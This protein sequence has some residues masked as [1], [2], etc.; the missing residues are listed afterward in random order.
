[1]RQ[2]VLV[3]QSRGLAHAVVFGR[4]ACMDKVKNIMYI[5]SDIIF[6]QNMISPEI[7]GD[8]REISMIS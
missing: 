2:A 5:T 8:I 7:S 4:T 3:Q 1:M 6:S